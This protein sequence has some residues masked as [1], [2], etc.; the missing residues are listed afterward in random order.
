M[1]LL[2]YSG[3]FFFTG[4]VLLILTTI[5]EWILGNFFAF[6][7]TYF[8]K[9]KLIQRGAFAAFFLSFGALVDPEWGIAAS[10][11][12]TGSA[13]EGASS[14]GYNV[15]LGFYLIFWGIVVF[16]LL[17]GSTR[18]N[19][20][21]VFVFITL[22]AG[23]LLLSGAFFKAAGGNASL[24]GHLQKLYQK[25]N[26]LLICRRGGSF[27]FATTLAVLYLLVVIVLAELG[28]T[29]PLPVGDLSHLWAGKTRKERKE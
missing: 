6:L 20:V 19:A 17:V 22:D 2:T 29:I 3:N 13:A 25:L 12:A 27:L 10:Y 24:A 11:S 16:L 26:Q 8:P 7:V 18:T 15:A 14:H 5:F 9:P 28:F 21:F 1:P 4:S 23:I